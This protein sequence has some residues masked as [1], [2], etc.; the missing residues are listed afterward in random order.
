MN[1]LLGT[2]APGRQQRKDNDADKPRH[3]LSVAETGD[4]FDF[5]LIEADEGLFDRNFIMEQEDGVDD[6]D[7]SYDYC[8]DACSMLSDEDSRGSAMD[9]KESLL[10]VPDVLM[11]DLDEAHAAAKLVQFDEDALAAPQDGE[12]RST[13]SL[14]SP[15]KADH[16]SSASSVISMEDDN[17]EDSSPKKQERENSSPFMPDQKEFVDEEMEDALAASASPP[18]S[19]VGVSERQQKSGNPTDST[20]VTKEGTGSMSRTSNKKRRKKLKVLKKAQAAASAATKLAEKTQGRTG[21]SPH[22]AAVD[23]SKKSK[24]SQII[25]TAAPN[26]RARSSKKVSNIAVACATE[27]MAAYRQELSVRGI[28]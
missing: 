26:T 16:Y 27:T 7:D 28:K 18:T 25:Q 1:S 11:K 20:T 21:T 17:E 12:G 8:E 9:L 6:D 15:K 4:S 5:V 24:A 2:S 3:S 13:T 14:S 19:S 10:S 23:S 22:G